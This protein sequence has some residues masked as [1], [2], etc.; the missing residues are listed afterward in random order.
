MTE[1]I[2]YK[3][4]EESSVEI[5]TTKLRISGVISS[6]TKDRHNDIVEPDGIDVSQHMTNPV[7]LAEHWSPVGLSVVDGAYTPKLVGTLWRATT[8]FE[9]AA[10]LAMQTF[11]LAERGLMRGLSI[12]FK[13]VEFAYLKEDYGIRWIK[14]LLM[15]Y[16]H[17][18][19][20]SNP[21]ALSDSQKSI[22]DQ[23]TV[24]LQK[25]CIGDTKLDPLLIRVLKKHELKTGVSV[26]MPNPEPT[27]APIAPPAAG[28]PGAAF[29]KGC[30]D[31]GLEFLAYLEESGTKKKQENVTVQD[32]VDDLKSAGGNLLSIIEATFKSEYGDETPLP[33]REDKT[34]IIEVRKEFESAKIKRL[35]KSKKAIITAAAGCLDEVSDYEDDKTLKASLKTAAKTHAKNLR[36]MTT[37]DEEDDRDD[38]EDDKNK[39]ILALVTQLNAKIADL[40]KQNKRLQKKVS[41][42]QEGK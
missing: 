26:L 2:Q 15:E 12:A 33:S 6:A 34:S 7:V 5:D 8:Q 35:S 13:P 32:A 23:L 9:E 41:N 29:L 19:I 3:V 20:P 28:S 24:V 31:R 27:P 37:D 22:L 16:S 36:D 40:E 11:T 30:Y 25:K 18:V 42:L 38:D 4:A 17:C 21:E 14:C 10:P 1:A 39:E